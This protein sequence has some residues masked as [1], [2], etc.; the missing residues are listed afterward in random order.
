[1]IKNLIADANSLEFWKDRFKKTLGANAK[2]IADLIPDLEQITGKLPDI[3]KLNPT[4]EKNR[5]NLVF[6]D[7]VNAVSNK[8]TPLIIYLDDIQW[9]DLS[10]LELIKYLLMSPEME[11][12]IVIGAYRNNEIT[13]KNPLKPILEEL[14]TRTENNDFFKSIFLEPLNKEAVNELV[15]DTLKCNHND[16][17]TLTD[18]I[19]QKTKGNP[20]FTNQLLKSLYE[21][22][23][24][25]FNEENLSWEWDLKQ[26]EE[27]QISDNVIDFLIKNLYT[28]SD[29]TL[30]TIKLASCIGDYF[31]LRTLFEINDRVESPSTS[32]WI[33][34]EKELIIP[35]DNNYRLLLNIN[36]DQYLQSNMEIGFKFGHDRIRQVIYSLVSEEDKKLIHYKIGKILLSS[37]RKNNSDSNIFELVNHLNAARDVIFEKEEILELAQLNE[38]A[39]KRANSNSAYDIAINYFN[40]GR[41][42]LLENETCELPGILFELSYNYAE[43]NLLSG[44]IDTAL[45]FCKVLFD[46]AADNLEKAKVYS[47]RTRIHYLRGEK[48]EKVVSEISE[49][50]K[51]FDIFLPTD[52]KEI[53]QKANEGICKM[54]EKLTYISPEELANTLPVMEDINQIT[55]VNLLSQALGAAFQ[56]STSLYMLIQLIMFEMAVKCGVTNMYCKIFA[57][58]GLIQGSIFGKYD[59]SYQF[60][61]AS[62]ILLDRLKAEDVRAGTYYVFASFI[63]HWKS[64]YSESLEY[65]NLAMNIALENGDLIH[66]TFSA[67]NRFSVIFYTGLN[68]N[69]CKNELKNTEKFLTD[70]NASLILAYTQYIHYAIDQLQLP[71]NSEYEN[72]MLERSQNPHLLSVFGQINLTI[73]F[74]LGNFEAAQ[75]WCDIT[76]QYIQVISG[77][78]N[79]VDYYMFQSFI[80]IRK[81]EHEPIEKRDEILNK[82]DSNLLRLKTWSDNCPENFAHKYYIV[83]AEIKRVQ[84]SPLETIIDL[85]KKSLDSIRNGD[86]INLRALI[87]E[88]IGEFWF[89]REYEIIGTA[90]TREACYLYE[91]WGAIEKV[92]ILNRK[93]PDI[94]NKLSNQKVSSLRRDSLHT[95]VSELDLMSILKASQAISSEIKLDKLLTVLLETVIENAGAQNGFI[96][97]KNVFDDNLYVEAIK[98]KNNEIKIMDS[99]PISDKLDVCLEILQAVIRT[100]EHV[101]IEDALKDQHYQYNEYIKSMNVRSVLCAPIIYQS[102]LKGIIYLE[103][104]LTGNA[105]SIKQL[106]VIKMLSSQ[107]AISIEKAQLSQALIKIK[108]T[109]KQL[110]QSEKMASLGNLVAGVAH[111]INTPLGVAVTAVSH[112]MGTTEGI[113]KNYNDDNIS[114][115]EFEEYLNDSM[116]TIELLF[117][118]LNK[119]ASLINGFKRVSADMSNED[120]RTFILKKYINDI[121]LSLSPKLKKYKHKIEV[122]CD[123]DI[124]IL[125]Y[126]GAYSQ[127]ITN[128]I[129][130]SIMHAYDEDDEGNIRIKVIKDEDNIKLI[131]S[132]DGKG[133]DSDTK[134]KIFEPFFTTNRHSGTGLGMHIVF[135]LVTQTLKGT[136][137]CESS[138]NK[139]TEFIIEFSVA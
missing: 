119:A 27:A 73:N 38:K 56:Y 6:R 112:M 99:T 136:I 62:F 78:F 54:Q 117:M 1:L 123:E 68:L 51:L 81:Y 82:L 48:W 79:T 33:A 129:I 87:N 94:F 67:G 61:R 2:I 7:F 34:I 36:K 80:L 128:L 11:N 39:G 66:A 52:Q 5:F 111:E 22:G 46:L 110:V 88:I 32:V 126:P 30:N 96:V 12:L 19:Y 16:T 53:E 131:Y 98:S 77:T 8:Q 113:I 10:S 93:Y 41:S 50:L 124:E 76:E 9:S 122:F 139:G 84:N 106:E 85:Y 134:S 59:L 137:T 24:F 133:M 109:Q 86:F 35:L 23:A 57:E 116:E 104:N 64:H 49:A 72:L 29:E 37:Y 120:K 74:I 135:N 83:L 63:S 102:D 14:L 90:Y 103:N 100:K 47:L 71:Y 75:K 25:R 114:K 20:F 89:S 121:L 58:F 4:E 55:A 105:F 69:I 13:E 28:L 125:S 17:K 70:N 130:N 45:D 26:I 44:N 115:S 42:L 15:A 43:S 97:L 31:N 65:Y 21:T 127:I 138:P 95:S 60:G 108:E 107:I 92:N 40:V 3:I 101:V 118:N 18:Y 132:D 91:Q